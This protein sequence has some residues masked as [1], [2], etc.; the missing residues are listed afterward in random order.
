MKAID[1]ETHLIA[2]GNLAPRLVCV[3]TAINTDTMIGY[4][5][6]EITDGPYRGYLYDREGTYEF[7]CGPQTYHNAPFDLATFVEAGIPIADIFAALDANDVHCTQVREKLLDIAEGVYNGY[8]NVGGKLVRRTYSLAALTRKYVGV[9]L[10]KDEWRLRYSELDGVPLAQW[11]AGARRYAT[12]DAISTLQVFEGQEERRAALAEKLGGDPL[13][14]QYRQVRR[15]FSLHLMAAWGIRTDPQRTDR[16]EE[17]AQ[18][19]YDELV[20]TLSEVGLVRPDG[21]RNTKAA[22]EWMIAA[23]ES[24]GVP[25]PLTKTGQTK[26]GPLSMPAPADFN[27]HDWVALDKDACELSQDEALIQYANLTTQRAILSKDVEAL[28]KGH[29]QP[30]HT[31]INTILETGRPSSSGPNI[32]NIRTKDTAKCSTCHGKGFVGG[33]GALLT[34]AGCAECNGKGYVAIPSIRECFVPRHGRWF[35]QSDYSGLELCTLAQACIALVGYSQLGET[36]NRYGSAGKAHDDFAKRG[37]GV[38][39]DSPGWYDARQTAKVANF[40]FP[41]G[42]GIDSLIYFARAK[43]NVVLDRPK[44]RSLKETWLRTWPEMREYFRIMSDRCEDGTTTIR[45]LYSGRY[46]GRCVYTQACNSYFQGLGADATGLALYE[47]QRECYTGYTAD[48]A[49]SP[50]YGARLVNYIYDEYILEVPQ[51]VDVATAMAARIVEVGEA[52]AN[53]FLPDVPVRMGE[54]VLMTRWSKNAKPV[55]DDRGRLLP[56]D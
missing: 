21:S 6:A 33:G 27:P 54:P 49:E 10:E 44:A 42:L 24:A 36:I 37:L 47:I 35:L 38:A 32:F 26:R 14:D 3:S 4:D 20:T 56:W 11:P 45:Q 22:R 51:D 5:G 53:R 18:A 12:L 30:I 41:G 8:V 34:R 46:R 17:Y 48:G 13:E 55:Y 29:T 1:S 52:H 40:G 19:I 15:A 31:R 39:P 2:P 16:L 28:R 43:Y 25:L 50:L 23:C 7:Y 9:E